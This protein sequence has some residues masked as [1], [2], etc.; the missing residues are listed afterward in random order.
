MRR[1][2]ENIVEARSLC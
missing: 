2:A 1:L